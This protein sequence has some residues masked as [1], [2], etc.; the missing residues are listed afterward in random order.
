MV[1]PLFIAGTAAAAIV[2][3]GAMVWFGSRAT[4]PLS[5]P[6]RKEFLDESEQEVQ[7]LE[8]RKLSSDEWIRTLRADIVLLRA[9]QAEGWGDSKIFDS[10][11]RLSSY[12]G[13]VHT[14]TGVSGICGLTGSYIDR[15]TAPL[16]K[17]VDAI[18]GTKAP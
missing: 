11:A 13:W 18:F 1:A 3:G 9:H 15:A 8:E 7:I 4:S 17:F 14:T 5:A 10:A 6:W 16:V 2:K 12:R